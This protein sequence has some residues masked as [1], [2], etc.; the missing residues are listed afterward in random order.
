MLPLRR[1]AHAVGSPAMLAASVGVVFTGL[2][3]AFS[4]AWWLW[5]DRAVYLAT[6]WIT[7]IVQAAQNRD[8]HAMQKKLDE[9]IH[10]V[11]KADNRLEGIEEQ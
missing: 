11:D 8:T 10:A 7:V 1:I 2:F 5:L 9:L 4:E 6:L 3:F